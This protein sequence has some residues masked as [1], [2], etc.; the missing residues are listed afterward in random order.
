MSLKEPLLP[1]S[2]KNISSYPGYISGAINLL[3]SFGFG[4]YGLFVGKKQSWMEAIPWLIFSFWNIG[5][6]VKDFYLAG[7]VRQL[8]KNQMTKI[9]LEVNKDH[10]KLISALKDLKKNLEENKNE[11]ATLF[12]ED[13]ELQETWEA[14][15]RECNNL[16]TYKQ[17]V[18]KI[19][20]QYKE[21]KNS[22]DDLKK[23]KTPE[24]IQQDISQ[25]TEIIEEIVQ[26]LNEKKTEAIDLCE[27]SQLEEPWH[28]LYTKI[29]E[30]IKA[31]N[32]KNGW[33]SCSSTNTTPFTSPRKES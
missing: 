19:T 32:E 30:L 14:I 23:E 22:L 26:G 18:E 15:I 5:N 28:S 31:V 8:Q 11:F 1:A 29:N 20:G 3:T 21:I 2:N 12:F 10:K 9:P 16:F 27:T 6:G 7:R 24:G 17:S 13:K 25:L 33:E 4:G